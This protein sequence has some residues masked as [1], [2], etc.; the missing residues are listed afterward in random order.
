MTA[1]KHIL[2]CYREKMNTKRKRKKMNQRIRNVLNVVLYVEANSTSSVM[3][4]EAKT[5]KKLSDY[6]KKR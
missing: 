2:G 3:M 6:R 4:Y 1:Q 5:P